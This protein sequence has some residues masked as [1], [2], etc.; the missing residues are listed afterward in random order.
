MQERYEKHAARMRAREARR[1][2][3]EKPTLA[4]LRARQERE[5]KYNRAG[6][7]KRAN[8][9]RNLNLDQWWEPEPVSLF[10]QELYSIIKKVGPVC[11]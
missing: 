7:R 1:K 5:R 2:N 11:F 10:D 3:K 4:I 8:K 6:F 9:A